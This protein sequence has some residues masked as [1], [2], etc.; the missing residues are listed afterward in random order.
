MNEARAGVPIAI[1]AAVGM[2][3]WLAVTLAAG[4]REAWD[5]GAYWSVAYPAALG[6]CAVLGYLFPQRP[7]RWAVVLFLAQF[8]AMILRNGELGS[9]WPLGLA[10]FAVLSLPGMLAARLGS[11]LKA[12]QAG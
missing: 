6:A 9:L 12:R 3:L 7:W 1:A 8:A 11:R 4:V 10:L 2:V 5:T